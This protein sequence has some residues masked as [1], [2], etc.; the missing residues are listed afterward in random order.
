M[1]VLT[2]NPNFLLWECL[3]VNPQR[4][5]V[6][7]H[8]LYPVLF[9]WK[10]LPQDH[11]TC[12]MIFKIHLDVPSTSARR[13]GEISWRPKPKVLFSKNCCE[14]MQR[15]KELRTMNCCM[16]YSIQTSYLK[17]IPFVHWFFRIRLNFPFSSADFSLQV[18]WVWK[19]K[20]DIEF[21]K[22]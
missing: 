15:D 12:A 22:P 7:Y 10:F 20:W 17:I 18:S 6:A 9:N 8:E 13:S 19:K 1:E 14:S 5:E 4:Q 2:L 11:S 21:L 16:F 3:L